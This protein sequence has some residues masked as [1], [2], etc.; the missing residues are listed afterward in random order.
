MP[1]LGLGLIGYGWAAR[2]LHMGSYRELFDL[3]VV[4]GRNEERVR[5]FQ[6]EF[7]FHRAVADY[8]ELLAD[9]SVQVVAVCTPA[10]T[11][12]EILA[13]AARAGKHI[14]TEKPLAWTEE[15]A[16]A[17]VEECRQ[18]GVQ[19]AVADQYR[20]FPHIREASRLIREG[21]IGRPF[22]G[23]VENKLYFDFPAYPGQ[24]LGFVVEQVT[25]NFD[26]LRCLLDE[27]FVEVFARMGRSPA[28]NQPSDPREFWCAVT[29]GSASGVVIQLLISW[30]C[31]GLDLL[32][33]EIEQGPEGRIHI[34]GDRGTL[35]LNRGQGPLL[36]VYSLDLGG[37]LH[38]QLSPQ[39]PREQLEVYGT[40]EAM[41][42]FLRCLDSGEEHSV[43]GRRYC[44]T[45]AL[46]FAAY[47]SAR[48]G[49]PV[50]VTE[51]AP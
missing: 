27:E 38:P 7:G 45:L 28:R 17:I 43:S 35:F 6:K 40:G 14:F 29:L 37:W 23:Q 3:A 49:P 50:R 51:G 18:A 8:R 22:L 32:R 20:Y 11:R 39:V 1:K 9:P 25:H 5:A 24:S 10:S 13:T 46:A 34:E 21:R 2:T 26:V 41:R 48:E 19:L 47:R 42:E 30:A 15:D 33:G 44:R 31:L 16:L 4:A 36:S 12:R